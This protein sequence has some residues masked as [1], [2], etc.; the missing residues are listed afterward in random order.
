MLG[1]S[2]ARLDQEFIT[3][4]VQILECVGSRR[5][6]DENATVSAAIESNSERLETFLSGRV[7]NLKQNFAVMKMTT[8]EN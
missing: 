8:R 4:R 7:P 1:I 5:V 2:W 6:E 3:P